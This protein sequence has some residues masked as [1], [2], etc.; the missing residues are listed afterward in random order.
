M[1][2]VECIAPR[3]VEAIGSVDPSAVLA[4]L[5]TLLSKFGPACAA[6]LPTWQ[7][8]RSWHV[9]SAG[10]HCAQLHASTAEHASSHA[11]CDAAKSRDF[12]KVKA[13]LDTEP[14]LVN[15]QPAQRWSALH[16]FSKAGKYAY[17]V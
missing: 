13:M 4:H 15:V 1:A 12:A 10:S 6:H 9:L 7:T 14:A 2:V 5:Q 17:P 16:Q 11:F 3:L 8:D